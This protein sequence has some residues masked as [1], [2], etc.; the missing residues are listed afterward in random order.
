MEKINRSWSNFFS[1]NLGHSKNLTTE[2][3]LNNRG[4]KQT[5]SHTGFQ[6][7]HYLSPA[8]AK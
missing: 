7:L 4:G 1:E 3:S 2:K 5:S 8:I 6:V